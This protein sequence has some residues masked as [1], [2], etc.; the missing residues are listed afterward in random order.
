MRMMRAAESVPSRPASRSAPIVRYEAREHYPIALLGGGSCPSLPVPRYALGYIAHRFLRENRKLFIPIGD[1][2]YNE[3]QATL[4][5][6]GIISFQSN[7][8]FVDCF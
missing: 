5:V 2:L 3:H 4:L 8:L 6:V 7:R 1:Q